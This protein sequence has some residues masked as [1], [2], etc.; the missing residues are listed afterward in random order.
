MVADHEPSLIPWPLL[1]WLAQ[2][3]CGLLDDL[4]HGRQVQAFPAHLPVIATWSN[5]GKF[6]LNLSVKG[7]GLVPRPDLLLKYART[8]E[9]AFKQA[10]DMDW[11]QSFPLRAAAL[12]ALYSDPGQFDP[13]LLGGLEI[14]EG[15]T[16][17]NLSED[18]RISLLF[19]GMLPHPQRVRYLSFQINGHV[20]TQGPGDLYYHFLLAARSLFEFDRFHLPQSHYPLAYLVKVSEALDKSPFIRG[21]K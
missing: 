7:I 13:G 5:Q 20:E 10:Q 2:S 16:L 17:R 9:E 1:K 8:F 14:F 19:M 12:R 18:P 21:R 11:G 4:E 3:R 6:P 15:R